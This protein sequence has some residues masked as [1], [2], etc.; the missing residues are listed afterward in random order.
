MPIFNIGSSPA[1][2][3]QQ[4]VRNM[5]ALR[6]GDLLGAD[7]EYATATG[8]RLLISATDR[9]DINGTGLTYD[10]NEQ[11]IGGV[12]TQIYLHRGGDTYVAVGLSVS[13][14]QAWDWIRRDAGQEALQTILSG[15]DKIQGSHLS[16]L[17][18]GYAGNDELLAASG[19]DS[20]FGGSG[21]DT[22]LGASNSYEHHYL[23]GEEGNDSVR[24]GYGFDDI[25]GNQGQDTCDGSLGNDW[26]VGGQDNDLLFGGEGADIVYGNLGNDTLSGDGGWQYLGQ[27]GGDWVRGGQGDDSISGGMGNDALWGDRGSDTLAGGQ[28]ADT[29][30]SFAGAGLDRVIDFSA[31]EGDRVVLD[32]NPTY[33]LRQDGADAIIDLGG[34]DRVVLV[35]VNL[36][37]LP[38]GWISAG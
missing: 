8:L 25:H 21:H 2:G 4:P 16:D 14:V 35:G 34:A 11:L 37:T 30:H 22:V 18:R 5:D 26:V 33:V 38:A 6:L 27:A 24:G 36:S 3:G 20:L 19:Q 31:A 23:R 32:F 10:A 28:G 13:A 15:D 29:F 9:A 1:A 17:V 7:I 12:I